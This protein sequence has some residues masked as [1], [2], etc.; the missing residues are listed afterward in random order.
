MLQ[1]V[2]DGIYSEMK[3]V[4]FKEP[5]YQATNEEILKTIRDRYSGNKEEY[6]NY[7]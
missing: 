5:R 6:I 7:V 4:S 2:F 3:S 1:N